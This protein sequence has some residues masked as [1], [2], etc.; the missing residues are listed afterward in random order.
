[1]IDLGRWFEES[2]AIKGQEQSV[3]IEDK[4]FLQNII[5]QD[6]NDEIY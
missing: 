6:G 4:D 1:M 5:D 3:Y 2:Y